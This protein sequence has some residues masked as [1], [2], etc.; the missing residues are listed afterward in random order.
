MDHLNTVFDM[1]IRRSQRKWETTPARKVSWAVYLSPNSGRSP[2]PA[3][4]APVIDVANAGEQVVLDLE[5]Q[6]PD[7]P[8]EQ[9]IPRAK[10]TVDSTWCSAQLAAIRPVSCRGREKSASSTQCA[11]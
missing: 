1:P 4:Q 5:V 10:S 2:R 7:E 3:A 8:R 11:N 6:P 9:P